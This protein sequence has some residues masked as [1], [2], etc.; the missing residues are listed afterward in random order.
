MAAVTA[1]PTR[2]MKGIES[3]T[4]EGPKWRLGELLHTKRVRY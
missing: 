1:P 3:Y 4:G 2:V